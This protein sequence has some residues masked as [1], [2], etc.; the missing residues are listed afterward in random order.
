MGGLPASDV[1]CLLPAARRLSG[2]SQEHRQGTLPGHPQELTC[3]SAQ[4]TR[5]G[6][7]FLLSKRRSRLSVEI[8]GGLVTYMCMAYI[9]AVNAAILTDS[10]G[11]C[12]VN[13]CTVRLPQRCQGSSC[14]ALAWSTRRR[15]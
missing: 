15:P 6:Q 12:T 8:L 7:Y 2:C 11:P 9:L 14:G 4:D 13:D 3:Q 1:P 5:A 10:G